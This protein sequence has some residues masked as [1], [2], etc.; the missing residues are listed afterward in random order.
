VGSGGAYYYDVDGSRVRLEPAD[1]VA[2]DLRAAEAAGLSGDLLREV[3]RKSRELRGGIVLLHGGDLPDAVTGELDEAGALQPVFRAADG[4]LLVVLPEVRIE[5]ADERQARKIRRALDGAS[6]ASEVV[7]DKGEQLV[8]RP[9]SH[10]GGDA[11][12]LANLVAETVEPPM[13][14]ARFLRVVPRPSTTRDA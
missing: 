7:R 12:E 13:A 10:K 8:V 3:Q 14:Q 2:V 9:R 11:L 6:V 4:S 1:D 5:A